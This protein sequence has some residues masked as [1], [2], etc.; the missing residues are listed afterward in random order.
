MRIR[1]AQPPQ[2]HQLSWVTLGLALSMDG[3]DR[4][5][6]QDCGGRPQ[7]ARSRSVHLVQPPV[8]FVESALGVG[9]PPPQLIAGDS[10]GRREQLDP[11]RRPGL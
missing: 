10:E 9:D 8:L 1:P 6:A 4:L 3:R 11:L 5:R 7:M 2:T